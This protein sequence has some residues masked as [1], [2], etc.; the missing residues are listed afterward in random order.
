MGSRALSQQ[1]LR[2][3]SVARRQYGVTIEASGARAGLVFV[4]VHLSR[5]AVHELACP[6][7]PEP[8][9][10]TGVRLH[11]R[12]VDPFLL[13]VALDGALADGLA[14]VDIRIKV[15]SGSA[16]L[17]RCRLG[18]SLRATIRLLGPLRLCVG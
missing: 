4:Q 13:S 6:G 16:T 14:Q 1:F 15:V 7:E 18:G 8:F 9:L 11:L 12:H 5:L 2:L 3:G 17:L 10:G